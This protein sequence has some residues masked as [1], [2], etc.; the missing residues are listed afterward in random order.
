M[1]EEFWAQIKADHPD[2]W[3]DKIRVMPDGYSN[4]IAH[5]FR[6]VE[7]ISAGRQLITI[8]LHHYVGGGIA[9]SMRPRTDVDEITDEQKAMLFVLMKSWSANGDRI[10][11]MCGRPSAGILKHMDE[12]AQEILCSEHMAERRSSDV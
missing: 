8:D 10:C 1:K 4:T 6:E 12:L 9:A 3:S 5:L 7:Q 11:Q 2:Y